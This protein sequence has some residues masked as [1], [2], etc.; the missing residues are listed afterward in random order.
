MRQAVQLD[1]EKAKALV[2]STDAFLFDCDG[3]PYNTK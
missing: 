3:K 2:Q 1:S